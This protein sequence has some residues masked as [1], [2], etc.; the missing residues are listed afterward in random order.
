MRPPSGSG[1]TV[2]IADDTAFV[3]DRF[4]AALEEAGHTAITVRSAVELL[5]RIRAD[6]PR[7]DLVVL[8][9]RLPSAS[10]VDLVRSIRRLDEGRLPIVVFSG[11]IASAEEVRELSRLGISGYVNEYSAAQHI[12][13]S[14]APHL[15]P[16]SFN[17]RSSP[18]VVLGIPVS[19][20]YGNTIAAAL[21]LNLSRGGVAIRTTSPLEPGSRLRVRLRLPGG[22]REIDAEARVAWT[23]RRVGMG[24]QFERVDPVDQQAIDEFVD[25]HFFSNRKA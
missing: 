7:L 15:F 4:R 11:T 10:G 3:R 2:V 8:D 14:L 23:D 19:Y 25:S 1:K 20:R 12:L 24:L 5:A 6:L 18:R 9:L 21:T 16:D 17:R 13:P 22:N